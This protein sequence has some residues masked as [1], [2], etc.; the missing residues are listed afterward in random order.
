M[1]STRGRRKWFIWS[2]TGTFGPGIMATYMYSGLKRISLGRL[3]Q[4]RHMTPVDVGDPRF[5]ERK[6]L[7]QSTF[8]L[9]TSLASFSGPPSMKSRLFWGPL[10]LHRNL[11]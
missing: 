2:S 4:E 9:K 1:D 11:A 10:T 3:R 5:V 6:I 7:N 8:R